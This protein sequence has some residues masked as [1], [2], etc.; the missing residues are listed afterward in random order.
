MASVSHAKISSGGER[1]A[2][3]N[4]PKDVKTTSATKRMVFAEALARTDSS[5]RNA[6]RSALVGAKVED[7][8]RRTANATTDAKLAGVAICVMKLAQKVLV[9][10][11][12]I[13]RQASPKLVWLAAFHS[14]TK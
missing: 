3:M 11:D 12:A 2:K 4:A 6:T 10:K 8:T 13:A 1:R 9:L 5:E 14:L 7:V